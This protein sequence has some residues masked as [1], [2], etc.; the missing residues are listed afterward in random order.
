M[1]IFIMKSPWREHMYLFFLLDIPGK[2]V[3]HHAGVIVNP[4]QAGACSAVC[5]SLFSVY[6]ELLVLL[7]LIAL[8]MTAARIQDIEFQFIK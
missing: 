6:S 8:I 7:T 3:I 4:E 5:F 2:V 1:Q